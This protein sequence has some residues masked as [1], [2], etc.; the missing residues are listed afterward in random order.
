VNY[1]EQ[2]LEFGHGWVVIWTEKIVAV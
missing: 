1:P 2:D